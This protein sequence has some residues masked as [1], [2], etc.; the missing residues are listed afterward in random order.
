VQL[1]NPCSADKATGWSVKNNFFVL[2]TA[3]LYLKCDG[4]AHDK[5][6]F[7]QIDSPVVALT[8][9]LG[10]QTVKTPFRKVADMRS[11]AGFPTLGND[12]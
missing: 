5:V 12:R 2:E 4:P 7:V 1:A 8:L 9:A 11:S 6:S 3:F 10:K